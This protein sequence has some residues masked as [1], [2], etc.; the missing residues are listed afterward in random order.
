[1]KK[2]AIVA[3]AALVVAGFSGLAHAERTALSID[4]EITIMG[5]YNE[6]VTVLG[7]QGN[8][9]RVEEQ[10]K[11]NVGIDM[12]DNISALVTFEANGV[13]GDT[14]ALGSPDLAGQTQA[15]AVEE[16]YVKVDEL[17]MEQL[18]VTA[19]IQNIEYQLR[20]DGNAMFLSS[21]ETAAWKGTW[22]Y[23]PLFVDFIIA[24]LAETR[25]SGTSGAGVSVNDTDLYS[26]A[27]EYFLDNDS[28]VQ[29]MLFT[30]MNE[31]TDTNITEYA[32]GVDYKGIENLE[33]FVQLGGQSGELFGIPGAVNTDTNQMAYNLGGEYTFANVN[34]TP[35]VGLSYQY[36]GGDDT[37]NNWIATGDVDE[38]VVLEA[39]RDLRDHDVN[40][41]KIVTSNYSAIRI[42][43]G[44][45]IN[46]KTTVDGGIHIL[47]LVEDAATCGDAF[48]GLG[49][50][51]GAVGIDEG[52]GTEID[53]KVNHQFTDDLTCGVG[54][55]Y[56]ATGDA[57]DDTAGAAVNADDAIIGMYATATLD[58]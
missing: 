43:G 28:K 54:L 12:T 45:V 17:F 20:D 52:I 41:T 34:Y 14:S 47:S 55:G 56:V 2:F 40:G 11:L 21:P 3:L 48:N 6:N 27:V 33:I 38:T 44:A 23:D 58:F 15:M 51:G 24:K 29:V 22:D 37:D 46:E 30:M 19:G 1:M 5:I 26:L 32:A 25:S 39:D 36:F 53:V 18:T 16:A 10:V 4:G 9:N 35:Y 13:W 49:A 57:I 42:V 8:D 31:S 7:R 50:I